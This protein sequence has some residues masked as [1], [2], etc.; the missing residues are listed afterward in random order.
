MNQS[1]DII[2]AI[3]K[4]EPDFKIWPST[5]AKHWGDEKVFTQFV[6]KE[7]TGVLGRGGFRGV[8]IARSQ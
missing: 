6:N 8:A 5:E 7:V 2:L 3:L 1:Q 4:R